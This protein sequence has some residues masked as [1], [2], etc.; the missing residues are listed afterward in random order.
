M[1]DEDEEKKKN[2]R[3]RGK[4]FRSGG[5]WLTRKG[6]ERKRKGEGTDFSG[7]LYLKKKQGKEKM[8][9]KKKE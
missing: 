2:E 9:K 1:E 3:K 5:K 7:N 8:K 6:G 4:Y